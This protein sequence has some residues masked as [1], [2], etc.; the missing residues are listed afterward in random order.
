VERAGSPGA[1]RA[2]SA[3]LDF[4]FSILLLPAGEVLREDREVDRDYGV[5]A[6]AGQG[7]RDSRMAVCRWSRAAA[8]RLP[9]CRRSACTE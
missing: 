3:W 5:I 7:P 4:D 1:D 9:R 8:K 2:A 6:V